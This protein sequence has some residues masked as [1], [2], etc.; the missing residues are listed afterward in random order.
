MITGETVKREHSSSGG[1]T[2]IREHLPNESALGPRGRCQ[3]NFNMDSGTLWKGDKHRLQNLIVLVLA[4]EL[5]IMVCAHAS[6]SWGNCCSQPD[7]SLSIFP[8]TVSNQTSVRDTDCFGSLSHYLTAQS[9]I[10][11][12]LSPPD[13]AFS[14]QQHT[15]RHIQKQT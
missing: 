9:S 6:R 7:C 1:P 12:L 15:H 14:V 8:F 11:T 13:A 2:M 10:R 4:T 5:G 3:I